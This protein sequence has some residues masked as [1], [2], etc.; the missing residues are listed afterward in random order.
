[1]TEGNHQVSTM[2]SILT[3]HMIRDSHGYRGGSHTS[4]V[5][6]VMTFLLNKPTGIS[7]LVTG[8]VHGVLIA[9]VRHV[10]S[11]I[12]PG[13]GARVCPTPVLSVRGV[14]S[15]ASTSVVM[16]KAVAS[17]GAILLWLGATH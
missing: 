10:A 17:M 4:Q 5:T 16:H 6:M 3:V 8:Q 9:A 12:R 15:V 7:W 2:I 13:G 11:Q 1:M 14:E